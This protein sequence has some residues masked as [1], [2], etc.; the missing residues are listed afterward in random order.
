MDTA[1][2]RATIGALESAMVRTMSTVDVESLTKHHFCNGSY[3]REFF[4]PKGFLVTGKIH[5]F[6]CINI[7]LVGR[8]RIAQSDGMGQEMA[9]PHIYVSQAGEKKALFAMEDSVFLNVHALPP[10]LENCTE[11]DMDKLEDHFIVPSF[12]QLDHERLEAL[13]TGER[14]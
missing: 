10:E 2:Y 3:V 4:L 6:P 8:I 14:T 9:A 13:A 7:L 5:R 11:E 12:E 1:E